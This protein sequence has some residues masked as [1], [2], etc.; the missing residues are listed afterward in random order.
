MSDTYYSLKIITDSDVTLSWVHVWLKI[1]KLTYLLSLP[2][3]Y[4]GA[5]DEFPINSGDA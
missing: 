3:A 1:S 4:F 5:T 2:L